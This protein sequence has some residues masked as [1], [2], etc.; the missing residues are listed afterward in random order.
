VYSELRNCVLLLETRPLILEVDGHRAF[1]SF[2]TRSQDIEQANIAAL[3]KGAS[4]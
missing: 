3:P 4:N 2:W 1:G